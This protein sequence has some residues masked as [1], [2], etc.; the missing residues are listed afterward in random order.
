MAE[1]GR[2]L[3]HRSGAAKAY[4]RRF[5]VR[6]GAGVDSR[7]RGRTGDGVAAEGGEKGACR[8]G[9]VGR[10]EIGIKM[11]LA[12]SANDQPR[13]AERAVQRGKPFI[14]HQL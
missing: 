14:R 6:K 11:F 8:C 9:A 1:G 13:T 5:R 4:P 2:H 3:R 12:L 10:V 7:Q